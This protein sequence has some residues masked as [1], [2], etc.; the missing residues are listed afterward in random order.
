[1]LSCP[2]RVEVS[3]GATKDIRPCGENTLTVEYSIY[4]RTSLFCY[5]WP[6]AI[7]NITEF[8]NLRTNYSEDLGV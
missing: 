7:S 6:F 4:N 8:S 5:F 1:M 2:S 3:V